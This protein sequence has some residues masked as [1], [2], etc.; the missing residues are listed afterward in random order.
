[1]KSEH[2]EKRTWRVHTHTPDKGILLCLLLLSV[3]GMVMV[4]DSSVAIALRDFSDPYHFVRDQLRYFLFGI[5]AFLICL[6]INYHRWYQWAL[7]LFGIVLVLLLAVFLPGIGVSALGAHRWIR[8]GF[9]ALQPAEAAKFALIIYLAAWFSVVERGRLLAFT[10]LLGTLFGLVMLEPDLGTGV[11][12]LGIGTVLYFLS[13]ARFKQ[14]LVLIP[15]GIALITLLAIISPYRFSR[16]TTFLH[17]ENDPLGSSYQIRQA[18]LGLGSGGW[19]GVGIGQS[20]QKFEYLPEANTDSIFAIIGEESGFVG[21]SLV[22]SIYVFLVWRSFWVASRAKDRFGFLLASGVGAWI[23]IQATVNLAAMVA[24]IPL[25]GVPLPLISY[26]GSG[27][28]AVLAGLGILLN[29][30]GVSET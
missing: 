2:G 25:T 19:L 17:P 27:L 15:V 10:I 16:L 24:L 13:G 21:A 5:A 22:M 18:L 26:G 6:K 11:I 7:P 14:F 3:I 29:V 12:I 4:Y 8:M 20:R 1:M 30:S 28:V 23:G 9:L